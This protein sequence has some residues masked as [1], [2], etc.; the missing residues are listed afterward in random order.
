MKEQELPKVSVIVLTFNQANTTLKRLIDSFLNQ[1]YPKNKIELIVM[2]DGSTDNTQKLLESYGK[3][4]C[5]V[6]TKRAGGLKN[7]ITGIGLAKNDFVLRMAGDCVP[8]KFFTRKLMQQFTSPEIGFVSAFSE[9]GGTATAY[10][11]KVFKKAG[12]PD[13]EFS[14]GLTGYR[15][16]SDLAFRIWDA[17][18]KSVFNYKPKFEHVHKAKSGWSS[19]ILSYALS[20]LKIHRFD[21]LLY[22]K[23]PKRG[24]EF[25]DVKLGFIRNPVKDFQAATGGWWHGKDKRFSLS[26]P[27]GVMLI[28]NKT[29]LHS[30]AIILGGAIYVILVKIVRLYWSFKYRKLLI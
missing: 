13:L 16:D 19:G 26:S 22:K 4:I 7:F 30:L 10:R 15:D 8:D 6:T 29:P 21:P 23:H 25:F 24:K 28:S 5:F 9:N 3:R 27:Q 2:D 20:R 17:G 11:K 18:Y 1:D 12:L 14:D